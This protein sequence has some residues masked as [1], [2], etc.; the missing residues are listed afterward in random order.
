MSRKDA[1]L[2]YQW[3]QHNSMANL[4]DQL[5]VSGTRVKGVPSMLPIRPERAPM[6]ARMQ[7]GSP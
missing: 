4:S 2:E 1:A 5:F 3:L 6:E 7:A